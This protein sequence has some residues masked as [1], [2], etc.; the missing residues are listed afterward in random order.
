MSV[1]YAVVGIL[2]ALGVFASATAQITRNKVILE[3]LAHLDVPLR[4]LPFLA[5]CL[6]AGGI[7]LLVGLWYTPLGIA[8]AIGLV[9]YFVG[10]MA[11]H[12][13]KGDFKGLPAPALFLILAA[14]ALSL[15]ILPS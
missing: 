8:A 1:A 4:I 10:A 7:G 15:Q 2:L 3:T 12:M 9:L 6:A 5:T 13:R 11:A 14:V